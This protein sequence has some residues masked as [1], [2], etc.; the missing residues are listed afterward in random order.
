ME[1]KFRLYI[2]G[3]SVRYKTIIEKVDR[4]LKDSFADHY[5]LEVINLLEQSKMAVQDKVFA[6]PTLIKY[7]PPPVRKIVGDLNNRDK[8]KIFLEME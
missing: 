2:I 1:L 8:L 6:T 4:F 3:C 7:F 5:T